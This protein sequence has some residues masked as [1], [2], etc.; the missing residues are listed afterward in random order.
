MVRAE[1][2]RKIA[3]EANS[4]DISWILEEIEAAARMGKYILKANG[5]SMREA[6]GIVAVLTRLGFG[7]QTSFNTRIGASVII[8]W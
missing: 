3:D 6:E 7:V 5:I 1:E 8:R 4:L 2:F